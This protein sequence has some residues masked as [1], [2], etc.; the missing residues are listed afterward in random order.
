MTKLTYMDS[1]WLLLQFLLFNRILDV[2]DIHGD[3]K[4][5]L[6]LLVTTVLSILSLVSKII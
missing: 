4:T 5:Q 1:L 6:S 2:P 3:R